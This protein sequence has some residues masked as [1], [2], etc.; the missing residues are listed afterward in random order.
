MNK[1]Q[2]SGIIARIEEVVKAVVEGAKQAGQLKKVIQIIEAGSKISTLKAKEINADA[3]GAIME[4]KDIPSL[5]PDTIANY[6]SDAEKLRAREAKL[7]ELVQTARDASGGSDELQRM[8][9]TDGDPSK[10]ALSVAEVAEWMAGFP[11]KAVKAEITELD[12]DANGK[13][14][15]KVAGVGFGACVGC[16]HRLSDFFLLGELGA[17][18]YFGGKVKI[19]EQAKAQASDA[20]GFTGQQR[21]GVPILLGIGYNITPD[22]EAVFV[23][24]GEFQGQTVDTSAGGELLQHLKGIDKIAKAINDKYY[25]DDA[26]KKDAIDM[27]PLDGKVWEEKY[28]KHT[29]FVFT[30][31]VGF[32]IVFA[33]TP[34]AAFRVQY[35]CTFQRQITTAKKAGV[36][37][38]H[39]S[40]KIIAGLVLYM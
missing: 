31:C 38:F 5:S 35:R 29:R 10:T 1:L 11:E 19:R 14:V 24:G 36:E 9:Y 28:K 34:Q 8:F 21:F 39:S 37:I 3:K 12:L 17:D 40:H 4:E 15:K 32:A 13:L 7:T 18:I 23:V 26:T 16:K 30:P 22:F 2:P 6:A 33:A 20:P 27:S 25:S